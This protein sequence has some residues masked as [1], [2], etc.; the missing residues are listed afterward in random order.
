M[1]DAVQ[2]FVQLLARQLEFLH[3]LGCA[4]V[5]HC[6]YCR[7]CKSALLGQDRGVC[8]ALLGCGSLLIGLV[9]VELRVDV[10]ALGERDI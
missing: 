2:L 5:W 4:F 9:A 7:L 3:Q 8:L 10:A 6:S 1:R